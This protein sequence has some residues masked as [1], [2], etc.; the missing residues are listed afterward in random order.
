M[1]RMTNGQTYGIGYDYESVM[2]YSPNQCGY[3]V[4]GTKWIWSQYWNK[5]ILVNT[6]EYR[7]SMRFPANVDPRTVGLQNKLTN[8]DI[9]HLKKIHCPSEHKFNSVAFDI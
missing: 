6:R 1:I 3:Y 4:K 7:P 2:H 9:Q 5:Y 8:K